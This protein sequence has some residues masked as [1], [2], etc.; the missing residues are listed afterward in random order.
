MRGALDASQIMT[1]THA[2]HT[3]ETISQTTFWN[4]FDE[5]TMGE[6]IQ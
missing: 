5:K 1:V 2:S 4:G 6:H 3:T